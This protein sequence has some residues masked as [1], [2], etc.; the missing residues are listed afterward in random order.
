MP[1]KIGITM[2]Q[3]PGY[4]ARI[5][6]AYYE[7]ISRGGGLPLALPPLAGELV[8]PL[9]DG[10]DGL[11]LSG[12]GDLQPA[13]FGQPAL[14]PGGELE[15]QRDVFE[16]A[17]IRAAWCRKLPILAICRGVQVLNV[18]L[19][20]TLWQDARYLPGPLLQ[21]Q[22]DEP[23][24]QTSHSLRIVL[25]ALTRLLGTAQLSVNSHH[26]QMLRQVAPP[27]VAAAYAPDDVI[28]AVGPREEDRYCWGLQW[29]PERLEDCYSARIFSS[30][31]MAAQEFQCGVQKEKSR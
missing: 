31:V 7:K 20:G 3:E 30:F 8:E 5:R 25:P 12:G 27:L 26:H 11:L 18:A 24:S 13:Y 14:P 9:L 16:L 4:G 19:G 1:P 6:Q 17:L 23:P 28:E 15:P 21:H 22:Q 10:L 2:S 29:H